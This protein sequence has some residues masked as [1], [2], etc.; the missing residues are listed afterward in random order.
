[1]SLAFTDGHHVRFLQAVQ[2]SAVRLLLSVKRLA[3]FV[4]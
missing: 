1:V 4:K 2:L 3:S